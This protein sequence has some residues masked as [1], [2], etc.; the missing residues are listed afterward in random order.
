MVHW[1]NLVHR[2]E[3]LISVTGGAEVSIF[4]EQIVFDNQASLRIE[5]RTVFRQ[6]LKIV[7]GS[8]CAMF[9]LSTTSSRG[10]A[11]CFLVRV[12]KRAE[13]LF[14]CFVTR[15][16]ELLL[17]QRHAATLPDALRGEDFDH[18]STSLLLFRD[19]RADFL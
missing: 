15:C 11:N 1:K 8:Q 12:N 16:I 19:E 10:S 9:H 2:C 18:V 13:S 17:R 7:V 6:Q 3:T 4:I 14:L 5:I